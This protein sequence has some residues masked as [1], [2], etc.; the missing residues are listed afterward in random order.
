MAATT[1]I[2]T[3]TEIIDLAVPF[4]AGFDSR[5]FDNHILKAQRKYVRVFLGDDYYEEILTQVEG[6]SLSSD[7]NTL[8]ESYLKPMLAHYIVYERIPYLREKI[9]NS[10][11]MNDF[12][13]YSS[14]SNQ[15]G[16]MR[17]QLL[18]DAQDYEKQAD[19]FIRDAQ[20]DDSTKYP[21]YCGKRNKNKFGFIDYV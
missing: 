5:I 12:N 17:N 11:V 19:Q 20:E 6:S 3:T 9:T 16:Y 1:E 18:A 4:K 10:G 8:L 2:I 21:D 13:N 7:N 14:Q 15:I